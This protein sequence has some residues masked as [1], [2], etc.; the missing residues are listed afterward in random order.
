MRD[1]PRLAE[2]WRSGVYVGDTKPSTR[3]TVEKGWMLKT[4]PPMLGTWNRGPARWFQA[5]DPSIQRETE[6]PGVVSVNMNRSLDA[7]AGSCDIILSNTVNPEFGAPE[8]SPGQFGLSGY[9]TW[10][11]GAAQDAR[12]RWG[13]STNAWNEV[14]VP[15]ALL[16]TYVGFGGQDLPIN[17]AVAQG[18]L[19]LYGVW[20]VDDVTV[21]TGGTLSLKCRDMGKLLVDQQL[22]PPLVPTNLY[23]LDY[24]RWVLKTVNIPGDPAPP[25]DYCL[26]G[27]YWNS[28]TDQVY[29]E[30]NS[31]ATGHPGTDAFDASP[32]PG[33]NIP[34]AYAHQR[35]Y[36]LS[37]PMGGPNDTVWIEF[38]VNGGNPGLINQVY[39]HAWKG[40]IEGRGTH[41][42][43]VSVH[44]N[45]A[46]VSPETDAG[47]MTPHGLP[48]VC[49]FSPGTEL[50]P[51]T[52][53]N[54]Y[55]LP[56]DYQA[57]V[58]RL[59]VT[60]LL[61]AD[62]F[63][64]GYADPEDHGGGWRGG[65]RK[66]MACYSQ[67]L[68]NSYFPILSFA[69]A[70]IPH[71]TQ[72]RLGYWQVRANGQVFAFGD[73]RVY[74]TTS[75]N[76][77]PKGTVYGMAAH[78]SGQGYWYV[79]NF[80][81]VV[82][83]GLAYWQGDM[84][85]AGIDDVI[86]IAPTPSGN[87]YW[88]LRL[89]GAIHSFGDALDHGTETRSVNL[90]SGAPALARSL[91]AHPTVQGYWI[92]WMDGYIS[93]H[94]V[95]DFSS[96]TDRTNF[97]SGEYMAVL[98]HTA[99]GA[100]WWAM[101]TNGRIQI[102]GNAPHKGNADLTG[103]DAENWYKS[104]TFA[105][106]TGARDDNGYAI[107]STDGR[108]WVKGDPTG[109]G[110]GSIG[111]GKSTQR[112]DGSYKDYSDIVRELLLWSGFYLY[113]NPQPVA[114]FPDVFGNIEDT[115]AYADD[116][117][118]REMFD[119]KPVIESIKSLKEIVGF[120]TWVDP[121]GGFRWESPSWWGIGNFL[122]DGTPFATMPEIDEAVQLTNHSVVRTASSA[123]S[124]LVI[125]TQDPYPAIV[126]EQTPKGIVQT[127]IVPKTAPDLRGLCVPAMWI[128]GKFLRPEE[129]KVMADLIDMRMW[130]ARR[131][132]NVACVA[133]PLLDI[134]DQIRL[135]ERQT[136]EV[137][138]HYIRSIDFTHDLNSGDFRMT[139][140]TNW[141][142]GTPWRKSHSF[143]A[144][145]ARPQGDGYWQATLGDSGI[146]A[147]GDAPL[148]DSQQVDSHLDVVRALRPTPTGNG[149][150]TIDA[151][152]KI[153][154][155]G[156]AIHRGDLVEPRHNIIDMA[157]TPDGAGYWILQQ[158]GTIRTFGDAIH[159][160]DATPAPTIAAV[161]IESHPSVEGY[162][163]ACAD[164]SVEGFN[165]PV[166]GHFDPPFEPYDHVTRLRRSTSG[167]GYWLVTKL[168]HVYGY[169][170]AVVLG[171]V[172]LDGNAV[173]GQIW[174]MLVDPSDNYALLRINGVL[175]RYGFT[176]PGTDQP[177]EPSLSWVL[178]APEDY[179]RL[180][181]KSQAFGVSPEVMAFLG[182][183][184]SP[185][186][187]NAV[188]NN[189]GAPL[190]SVG[191]AT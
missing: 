176:V 151:N 141:L 40:V 36:W 46:W 29:G 111:A 79:D 150:Y 168:G 34:G 44:E 91:C 98:E 105:L 189:F 179:L 117:L 142:G 28:S 2:V 153:L 22:F 60:N 167:D 19:V 89:N 49:T 186:A 188:V 177:V 124:R 163:V 52:A 4:T 191:A 53:T 5:M 90:P 173:D 75:P 59:T 96:A 66:I 78:P 165:L 185:S 158:D 112:F 38:M 80:G 47:G 69:A 178:V 109:L 182:R 125:A 122:I 155:Y 18:Y 68:H 87:G 108:L 31:H 139:L 14:L 92:L 71:N 17:D 30:W 181:D 172:S 174:E 81:R 116:P 70:G 103:Y 86:D 77:G 72:N 175:E 13:H 56:R 63:P 146:Y 43:M 156:D 136:G 62:D 148:F 184:G 160:G 41:R 135:I 118:P 24:R 23:P 106:I 84:E 102:G 104:L 55:A 166:L 1:V 42:V 164:G 65:A 127:E 149:Y 159:Y 3:V 82:A 110:Y 83:A 137:Y 169:G 162:W 180:K 115:G 50:A 27:N 39:Y 123:R 144:G 132:A 126:G 130:F 129:Q 8:Q 37:E 45:G 15:N 134:N 128:N 93:A 95:T 67:K 25:G 64:Y 61:W 121:E 113:Q 131:T 11:H 187:N 94:N 6:I 120:A 157:L 161:A 97:T 76:S 99:D 9:Y 57:S 107:Q 183:T 32:E 21:S 73:A 35:S 119:K 88:L 100:G 20:L 170:D 145:A 152:G 190:D 48:Y 147:Y 133:N 85:N 171:S 143:Y 101:S 74:A 114:E 58:I 16:R 140:T 33:P 26:P 51:A 154:T 12:A 7:D 54:L 138:I 10:D